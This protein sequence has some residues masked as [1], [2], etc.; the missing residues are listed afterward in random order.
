MLQRLQAGQLRRVQA[1]A[2]SLAHGLQQSVTDEFL[3]G[4]HQG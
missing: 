4:R 3:C 2:C 1:Q